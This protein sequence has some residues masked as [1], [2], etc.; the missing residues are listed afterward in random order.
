MTSA[1][2][3][4]IIQ[5]RKVADFGAFD[6]EVTIVK[7][8]FGPL[9]RLSGILVMAVVL[10]TVSAFTAG[11]AQKLVWEAETYTSIKPPFKVLPSKTCSGAKC[12]FYADEAP[13]TPAAC[14]NYKLKVPRAGKYTLWIRAW[15]MDGCGN[16]VFVKVDG[17]AKYSMESGTYNK[18]TWVQLKKVKFELSAGEHLVQ[19]LYR[20]TGVGIDQLAL[21]EGK[22][23]PVTKLKPTPNLVQ[24]K[25]GD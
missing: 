14:V 19:V 18:W 4:R 9:V 16:S 20:E 11:A 6:T 5:S 21:I 12:V 1:N 8:K 17:G 24:K 2:Q 7:A 15:W 25:A 3:K 10:G 23:V 22:Y 13:E